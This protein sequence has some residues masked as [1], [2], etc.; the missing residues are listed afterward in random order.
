[1]NYRLKFKKEIN[2]FHYFAHVYFNPYSST[3]R[4]LSVHVSQT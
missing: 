4:S 3:Y 1:M 2:L